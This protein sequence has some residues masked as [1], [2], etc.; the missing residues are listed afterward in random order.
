M[1]K[2]EFID[3]VNLSVE[4]SKNFYSIS[5]NEKEPNPYFVGFGNPNAEIIIFGKEKGFDSANNFQQLKC[6]SIENPNEWNN[7][8]KKQI[9]FNKIKYCD[10]EYYVNAY[11][12]YYGK[13]RGGHTWNKYQ[14][15]IKKLYP[16]IEGKENDFLDK[17]FLS[18]IN[19]IPS[20][21]SKI[22]TF[23]NNERLD[24]L[25]NDFYK[26]FKIIILACGSY[27]NDLEIEQSFDVKFEKDISKP[28]Q[29]LKIYTGNQK[30]LIN[31]RQLSNSMKNEYLN[32]ISE[33]IENYRK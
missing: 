19:F 17:T 15:I 22:K 18:E 26:S 12:P 16:E 14:H 3:I 25:K 4:K 23:V 10:S 24:F 29:R 11:R 28:S 31:T 21:E 27:L 5:A 2:K 32:F 20:K 9:G 30:I 1:F 13:M 6:E 33:I 8:V 7:Y